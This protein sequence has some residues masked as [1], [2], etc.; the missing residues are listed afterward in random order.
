MSET[1][2]FDPQDDG[3]PPSPDFANYDLIAERRPWGMSLENCDDIYDYMKLTTE[4]SNRQSSVDR[5]IDTD[6]LHLEY[7]RRAELERADM[8]E[9]QAPPT[10][11][12]RLGFGQRM[13]AWLT[14]DRQSAKLS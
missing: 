3:E 10:P 8:E 12:R 5:A 4:L 1:I 13:M 2:Q 7:L 11:E 9:R 6:T 14:R